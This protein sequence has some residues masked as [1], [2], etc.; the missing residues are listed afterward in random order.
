MV[1]FRCSERQSRW[2]EE[3][4]SAEQVAPGCIAFD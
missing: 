3:F 1:D 2:L 4:D